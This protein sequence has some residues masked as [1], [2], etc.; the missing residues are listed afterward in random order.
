MSDEIDNKRTATDIL[1]DIESKLS[2]LE[3]RQQ[4]SENLLKILLGRINQM[5]AGVPAPALPETQSVPQVQMKSPSIPAPSNRIQVP[6]TTPEPVGRVINKDNFESRPKTSKFSD[7]AA[8]HGVDIDEPSQVIEEKFVGKP[9][10]LPPDPSG[11]DMVEA[12]ARG[13]SRG[14]RGPKN[15]AGP[16]SSISQ[17]LKSENDSPLFLANIEVFDESGTLIN[18][19]RTNTKGRWLMALAPGDYQVHVLK[20]F[21]PDSGKKPVDT[22]YQ[23]SIPPSD[24]P[25]ELDPL[26]LN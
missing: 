14:Q 23:I 11:D 18:Q 12:P 5:M 7:M 17:V 19:T 3:R 22:T 4:N 6:A 20:R 9:G 16:K 10:A 1:L 13:N 15:T 21:P 8:A 25:M 26:Q 24:K 2:I